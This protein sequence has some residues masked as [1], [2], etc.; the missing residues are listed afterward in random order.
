MYETTVE[1]YDKES[2]DKKSRSSIFDLWT[3]ELS[4]FDLNFGFLMENCI[5][6]N[7]PNIRNA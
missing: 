7:S 6:I 3:L 4:N 1:T 5:Y 2:Y